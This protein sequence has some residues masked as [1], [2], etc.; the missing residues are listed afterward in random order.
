MYTHTY[1]HVHICICIHAC[2]WVCVE[3]HTFW[4]LRTEIWA[5]VGHGTARLREH[6]PLMCWGQLPLP[7]LTR[8]QAVSETPWLSRPLV[9]PFRLQKPVLDWASC[10]DAKLILLKLQH[11]YIVLPLFSPPIKDENSCVGLGLPA[12]CGKPLLSPRCKPAGL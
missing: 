1:Q 5:N 2:V 3:G 8:Q 10:R 9:P 11:F 12:P 7:S 6:P 4:A